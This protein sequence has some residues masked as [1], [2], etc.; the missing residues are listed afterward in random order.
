MV[1]VLLYLY[2]RERFCLLL[3]QKGGSVAYRPGTVCILMLIPLSWEGL[4]S[5][6]ESC[7][8]ATSGEPIP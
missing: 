7:T 3:E 1:V 6:S 4:Q 2:L 5:R 8:T